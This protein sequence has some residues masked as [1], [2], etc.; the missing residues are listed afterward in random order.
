MK[1]QGDEA[2]STVAGINDE[3]IYVSVKPCNS[4]IISVGSRAAATTSIE[5][6]KKLI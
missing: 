4:I 1:G 5:K 3:L 2:R 6:K